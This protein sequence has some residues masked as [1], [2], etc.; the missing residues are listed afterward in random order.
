MNEALERL[1]HSIALPDEEAMRL[2]AAHLD[3]L[4]KPPGS[5]GKL[6][7][8]TIRAAGITG[9]P[10]PELS[11]KAVVVM[12]AD[13]GVCE[14]GVSAYPAEVTPQMLLNM[15]AG[16]AAVN[17]FAR[18]AGADVI[19]VDMGVNADVSHPSLLS[20]KIR[21]GTA[22]MAKGPAMTREEAEKAILLGAAIAD[23]ACDQGI[24][25]FVTG[26][27]GIGNT[28]ASA[29]V[30]CALTGLEPSLLVGRGTGVDNEGLNR[31]TAAVQQ[32]LSVNQP[33]REDAIDVLMKVGGLEI[34]GMAGLILG[35]AARRCPVVLDGFISG[36]AALAASRLCPASLDYMLASHVSGEK[37][38]VVLLEILGLEPMLQLDMRLGEGT[39]GVLSLHL[40]DSACA[41]MHEMATFASA[42]V[43]DGTGV[44]EV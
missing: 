3:Q 25:L 26:E 42:G 29:A 28:T 9:Q 17:V 22:N 27:L 11:R 10:K 38:H 16:G 41:V 39:G 31:K 12:A 35:A 2:A 19:C 43:S 15:L 7:S 8:L 13:H 20:R 44:P 6:E 36:A 18:Q 40:L 14:E 5:L 32:A 23:E 24:Q 4:T 30:A 37:G 34:A 21:K 33:N 1:V